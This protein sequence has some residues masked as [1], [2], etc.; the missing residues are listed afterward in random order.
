MFLCI[1]YDAFLAK[2]EIFCSVVF[3]SPVAVTE[4]G[5]M[6]HRSPVIFLMRQTSLALRG[7]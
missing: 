6:C 1:D 4:T 7:V 3:V 2:I 5:S